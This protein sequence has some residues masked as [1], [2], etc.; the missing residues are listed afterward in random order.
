M[1]NLE[2][3][4]APLREKAR[5]CC[6]RYEERNGRK[7][8]VPYNPRTG[9]MAQSNNPETFAPLPIAAGAMQNYDGLG[10]GIFS[11]LGAIDIDHCVADGVPSELARDIILTMN[12]YTELSPSGTGIRIL[13]WAPGFQYDTERYYINNQ[14]RGL[15][16]YIAGC[17]KKYVTVTGNVYGIEEIAERSAQLQQVLEKYMVRPA[18]ATPTAG[19]GVTDQPLELDDA[20]LLERA[21][22]ARNG[23]RFARLWAGDRTGYQS[24][25]EADLAL[26]NQLAFWT[27][28]DTA[29][30]DRLFRQSGLMRDKWDRRQSGSTYGA[31]TIANAVRNCWEV[32]DPKHV[33]HP[34]N[35]QTVQES[36]RPHDFSDAGNAEV[37]A[38]RYKNDLI[39]TDAL[40]WLWWTGQ[41][42]E[43]DDHKA[44]SLALELSGQMLQ[45]AIHEYQDALHQ[46]AEA[47][48][49]YAESGDEGDADALEQANTA[50]KKA[51][52]YLTHAKNARNANKLR[53]MLELSKPALVMRAAQLDANPFDLNTPAGIVDLNTGRIRPHDRRA[54]CSKITGAA[55]GE[56]GW[57]MW[58]DFLD[59]ITS[60]DPSVKGFLQM[61]AG[62]ALFGT[63]YHEGIILAYG[64]GRN[65]KS[66]F[67]NALG[68]AA[69][70]YTGAIA[71][72]TLTATRSGNQGASLA[73][74]RGKRLV[75]TGE[76]EEHQRLSVAMLK[77]LASTDPLR[78]EEK[79]RA[80]EDITPSHTIVLF[81]NHLPRVGST[82]SGT[83]RRLIVIPF[84]ATIP[85]QNGVANYGEVLARE[86]GP[87]ILAWAIEGA[88]NFARN[89][90]KLD[91]PDAVAEATEEYREREDWLSNFLNER[92]E[93]GPNLRVGAAELYSAYKL[94][95]EQSGE[96]V[97]RLND[98]NTA[99]ESAGYH[100]IRPK[101]KRTWEGIQLDSQT[102][103]PS[104]LRAQ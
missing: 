60:G 67:F 64:G 95:A 44:V 73:T 72:D 76:L 88:V 11:D 103:Y 98:F 55:P 74:L 53:N 85:V 92:C 59:T 66:T 3:L 31:I 14:K 33:K 102:I 10:V 37:F 77:R 78:I 12:S 8:K 71:V 24:R 42:W 21:K 50:A 83:W 35:F 5:F 27:A 6:W 51:K 94:W 30:M 82:D 104:Y 68:A 99:M 70:D 23:D 56:N 17:T 15:E 62:M 91:I 1:T 29:R 34:P 63:V 16:V 58:S 48:A 100:Q 36:L 49:K 20:A 90:Y 47:K 38:R 97:R 28:R 87:A 22:R 69:G 26:C 65:G 93:K 79:Y 52:A 18:G 81:T 45:E 32:Y 7:T 84:N 89:Q 25:S 40:G 57:Q 80:P 96:Y 9:G 54:Y 13:F 19:A 46:Q 39:F 4:P 43:R 2:Y 75:I 86:A 61:V 41:K 101:N